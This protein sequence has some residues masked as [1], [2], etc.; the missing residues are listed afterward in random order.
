MNNKYYGT[1]VFEVSHPSRRAYRLPDNGLENATP[2][3]AHTPAIGKDLLRQTPLDLPEADE[4]SIVRH[5]HNMSTNNFGVDTG[6][7]PLG[8][9]TMKYNPKINEE[10]AA[11]P[12]FSQMHPAAGNAAQGNLEL[13]WTL[14]NALSEI[15]GMAEFTLNPF[16]GAHGELT[17]LMVIR[18]AT[19][20]AA[21]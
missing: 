19:P 4:L 15:G 8:S 12:G 20:D 11:H 21:R 9:C 16:A 2:A 13:Y 17:G 5:Y 3:P 10:M 1:L 7:Y 18:A 14:Q 6:F